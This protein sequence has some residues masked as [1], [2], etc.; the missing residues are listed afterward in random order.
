MGA[1]FSLFCGSQLRYSAKSIYG[2]VLFRCSLQGISPPVV[3]TS[4][5]FDAGSKF[6]IPNNTPYI[7]YS[8]IIVSPNGATSCCCQ[9]CMTC[10]I[11]Q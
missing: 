10:L 5:D 6:H 1:E 9:G 2:C 8:T 11:C 3:R 7:R 4:E